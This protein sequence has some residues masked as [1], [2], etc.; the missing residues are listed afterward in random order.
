[1]SCYF[2]KTLVASLALLATVCA[3]AATALAPAAVSNVPSWNTAYSFEQ[4]GRPADSLLLGIHNSDQIE[5]SLRRDRIASDAK[6]QLEYTPVS[7]T[8]LTLPTKA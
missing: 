7:Y 8:H 6:L 3:Q 1:M 5:F 2:S 4:L